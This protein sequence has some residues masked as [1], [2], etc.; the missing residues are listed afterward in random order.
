MTPTEASSEEARFL[1][2]SL[3][4]H[5]SA[6]GHVQAQVLG[7]LSRHGDK[8][9]EEMGHEDGL[10]VGEA[11]LSEKRKRDH[12]RHRNKKGGRGRRKR[13]QGEGREG[14]RGKK[15]GRGW[16]GRRTGRRRGRDTGCAH[17]AAQ[18]EHTSP[19]SLPALL[20]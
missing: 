17:H 13:R 10:S 16:R 20:L 18:D 4:T 14:E 3:L 1:Q 11:E 12:P 6:P 7:S 15:E 2:S 19:L 8:G 5:L 9:D